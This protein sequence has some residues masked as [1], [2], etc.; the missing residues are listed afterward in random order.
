MLGF[1]QTLLPRL[2]QFNQSL[3]QV[4]LFVDKPWVLIDEDGRQQ[5]YIFRR[6]GD[7]L[8]SLDGQVQMGNW[9][10]IAPAQSILIDR[11]V[12][13]L[14]LNHLFFTDALLILARDGKPESRFVLAN[15][16]LIP[17]LNV[18]EY[19]RT[20]EV[21]NAINLD[22]PNTAL[23]EVH[24][25]SATTSQGVRLD[26]FGRDA[27]VSS[28]DAAYVNDER[29]PDGRYITEEKW[30]VY[31]SNGLVEKVFW[32]EKYR[33]AYGHDESI[34]IDCDEAGVKPKLS[35][36][37]FTVNGEVVADEK[38]LIVGSGPIRVKKG[39]IDGFP[40]F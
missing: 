21:R 10:Y 22:K 1:L 27:K 14:L 37:V 35:N 29:A 6:S 40:W 11:K 20:L 19:L 15:R 2:R 25:S 13:K 4:E 7:L 34:I 30:G 12:D 16:Q 5:T 18:G 9:E 24:K 28:G 31:I 17:D 3:E 32:P 33:L 26:F 36:R 23:S 8:M 38:Y 39:I